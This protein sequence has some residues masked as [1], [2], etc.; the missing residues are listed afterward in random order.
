MGATAA[1]SDVSITPSEGFVQIRISGTSA[2][3]EDPHGGREAVHATDGTGM[4][5]ARYGEYK[6][7]YVS[8][9][10]EQ[11]VGR[12]GCVGQCW[13]SSIHAND[14]EQWI[15]FDFGEQPR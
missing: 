5:I 1:A 11:E 15:Q 8:G 6:G 10:C 13:R 12:G 9:L 4:R 3:S 14:D 7:A 2:S